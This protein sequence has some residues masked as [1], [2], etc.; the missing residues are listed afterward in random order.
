LSDSFS[1]LAGETI[2]ILGSS[3]SLGGFKVEGL[4][5]SVVSSEGGGF[6]LVVES[7]SDFG[8]FG[9]QFRPD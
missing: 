3:A 7:V 8:L 5:L 6:K 9:K 1:T 2:S 4:V